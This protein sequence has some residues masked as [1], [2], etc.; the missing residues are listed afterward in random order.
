MIPLGLRTLAHPVVAVLAIGRNGAIGRHNKL[1]WTM[2]SDLARFR[3][4]TMGKPMI[5]GRRTF[6]SIG[7]AL[8]GR[9]SIVVSRTTRTYG[10]EGVHV[11]GDPQAAIDLA[12][13]RAIAMGA[14]EITV[15]GGAAVFEALM[16]DL[17]RIHLTI[18]DLRPDADTFL[19]P[20]DP[21][22]WREVARHR[23]PRHPRDEAHSIHLAYERA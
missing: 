2:P 6:D 13:D 22:V 21:Y 17:D 14:A 20:I 5:M 18:V 1:P 15:I 12:R 3:R 10:L 11:V 8:P 4:L 19:A 23:P 9:E 16:S 7:K